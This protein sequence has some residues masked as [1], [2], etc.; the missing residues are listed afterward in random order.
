MFEK[1]MLSFGDDFDTVSEIKSL[2]GSNVEK[3]PYRNGFKKP[4]SK[5][6]M[7]YIYSDEGGNEWTNERAFGT[8]YDTKGWKEVVSFKE[9]NKDV[10]RRNERIE[11]ELTLPMKRLVF[12][13]ESR[14]VETWYKFYGVFVIDI[15]KNHKTLAFENPYVVYK[16]ISDT[17]EGLKATM[18]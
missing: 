2:F 10:D 4:N 1:N 6:E 9:Y 15:E 11:E 13:R 14:L 8:K 5:D 12:W 18:E 17:Y 16:K 3:S 7:V